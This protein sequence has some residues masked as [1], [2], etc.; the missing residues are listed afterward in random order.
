LRSTRRV[1]ICLFETDGNSSCRRLATVP[2]L[3]R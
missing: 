2:C 3:V 1:A